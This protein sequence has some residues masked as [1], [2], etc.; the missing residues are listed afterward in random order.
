MSENTLFNRLLYR[1]TVNF[2][3]YADFRFR[4]LQVSLTTIIIIIKSDTRQ[5]LND[6]GQIHV[7]LVRTDAEKPFVKSQ[8]NCCSAKLLC[9]QMLTRL[10]SELP[11]VS[12][13]SLPQ[14]IQCH[15][16]VT[17]VH[18]KCSFIQWL[19][20]YHIL[21]GNRTQLASTAILGKDNTH[22]CNTRPTCTEHNKSVCTLQKHL[23][24]HFPCDIQLN[25]IPLSYVFS[26]TC[27][28][29]IMK[30]RTIY[31]I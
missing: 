9:D 4:I 12:M 2:V 3:Y 27:T 11:N 28:F 20:A 30:W 17:L 14:V 21:H 29:Y 6:T 25:H 15:L 19:S 8:I 31:D 1:P 24:T 26:Y 22:Y 16:T 18:D 23:F 13:P 10:P 5:T 7:A